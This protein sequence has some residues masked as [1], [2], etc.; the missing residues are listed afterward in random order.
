MVRK[1][2]V[3]CSITQG[4][5]RDQRGVMDDGGGPRSGIISDLVRFIEAEHG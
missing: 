2:G 5:G 3:H 1:E 4:S